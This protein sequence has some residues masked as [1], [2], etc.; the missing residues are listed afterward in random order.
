[1]QLQTEATKKLNEAM[2]QSGEHDDE[3]DSMTESDIGEDSE[4][5]SDIFETESEE[6]NEERNEKPL[7]LDA[8]EKFPVHS[9]GETEDFEEHL[10]QISANSRKEKLQGR[11]VKAPDL[12]E[13]DQMII[14]AASLLRKNRR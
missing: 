7:Y 9:N 5:L 2:P 1:M 8:F 14:Q 11:D 12:D 10:R 3:N 6:E 13:V 4:D